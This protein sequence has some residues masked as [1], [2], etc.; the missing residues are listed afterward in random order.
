MCGNIS[1]FQVSVRVFLFCWV[2]ATADLPLCKQTTSCYHEAKVETWVESFMEFEDWQPK[3][4]V[5]D[6]MDADLMKCCYLA[7][8]KG[9]ILRV[10]SNKEELCK[11]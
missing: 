5:P 8:A 3:K 1:R 7:I 10:E 6:L 4:L 11:M 2:H 9:N